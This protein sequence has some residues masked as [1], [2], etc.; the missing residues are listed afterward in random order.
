MNDVMKRPIRIDDEVFLV[1]ADHELICNVSR[2]PL[3]D[4]DYT[5]GL[6]VY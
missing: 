3:P 6:A 1:A 2:E 4:N 5:R